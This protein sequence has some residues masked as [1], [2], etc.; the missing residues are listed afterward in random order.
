MARGRVVVE[1][2]VRPTESLEKVLAAVKSIVDIEDYH[3]EEAGRTKLLVATAGIAGLRR[4]HRLLREQRILDAARSVLKRGAGQGRIVFYLHKQAA[5][6]GKIS[7]VGGDQES[8]MGAIRV[9]I[10]HPEPER[11]IDWLAPPTAFGRP[12]WEHDMPD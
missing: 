9:V 7:F 1:A 10:E 8:P 3:V 2:E 5:T 11:V 6:V 12:L 4:L